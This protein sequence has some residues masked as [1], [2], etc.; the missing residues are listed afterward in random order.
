MS[1]LHNKHQGRFYQY[2][3]CKIVQSYV[4]VLFGLAALSHKVRSDPWFQTYSRILMPVILILA[5][6]KKLV[7]F[8]VFGGYELYV[9]GTTG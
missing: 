4:A 9:K 3:K 8:P 7:L 5:K 1:V 6:E 2:K